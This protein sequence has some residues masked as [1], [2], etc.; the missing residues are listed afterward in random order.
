MAEY[1]SLKEHYLWVYFWGFFCLPCLLLIEMV[2]FTAPIHRTK[3]AVMV[4]F[5]TIHHTLHYR[6]SL[7]LRPRW[8]WRST[9]NYG[10]W[11]PPLLGAETQR[12][13]LWNFHWIQKWPGWLNFSA[14]AGGAGA[15]EEFVG[16]GRGP[17]E[18]QRWEG[19]LLCLGYYA[20]LLRAQ[21]RGFTAHLLLL[22]SVEIVTVHACANA[23]I[24]YGALHCPLWTCVGFDQRQNSA[25]SM[26]KLFLSM[27]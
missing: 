7:I 17:L 11:S 26:D 5:S 16:R 12:Q 4:V 14:K 21:L 9:A 18:R 24:A 22:P 13:F 10:R 27:S 3:K 15:L 6:R 25:V 8:A 20:L 2:Q 23:F 19:R 1:Y